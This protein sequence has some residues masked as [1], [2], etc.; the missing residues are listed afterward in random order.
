MAQDNNNGGT[1]IPP[2]EAAIL[3]SGNMTDLELTLP[4]MGD[5]DL[6]EIAIF[7]VACAMRFHSDPNFVQEQLEWLVQAHD[8]E[9][10]EG[11]KPDQLNS[12]NDD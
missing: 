2:T 1:V 4:D 11:M 12:A 7:L 9:V 8:S 10:D 3:T 5:S 6:P